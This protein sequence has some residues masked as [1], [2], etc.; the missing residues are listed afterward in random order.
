[1]EESAWAAWSRCGG[2]CVVGE[3]ECMPQAVLAARQEKGWG[4]VAIKHII[5]T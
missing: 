5:S 4:C 3:F 2:E 1:M